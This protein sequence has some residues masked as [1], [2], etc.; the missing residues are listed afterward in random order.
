MLKGFNL[1]FANIHKT[2]LHNKWQN[3][4]NNL[5]TVTLEYLPFFNGKKMQLMSN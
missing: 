5:K 3:K 4:H 1:K 2:F